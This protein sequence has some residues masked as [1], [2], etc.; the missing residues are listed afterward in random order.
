MKKKILII[1][2]NKE[3]RENIV[4]ILELS[5]FQVLSASNGKMGVEKALKVIPD[6][7][8]CDIIMPE[9][10][11]YGVLHSLQKHPQTAVIP[12]IFLTAKS[13]KADFRKGMGLGADDYL[14][15]P[16]EDIELLNAI[17]TRLKKSEIT[18]Q[19]LKL[20]Q[21][22]QEQGM[23]LEHSPGKVAMSLTSENREV[24]KYRKKH[25]LYSQ[26][27]RPMVVYFIL[28]GKVKVF[29][30][31]E[32]GK[33]LITDIHGPGDFVGFAPIL[34]ESYYS[35]EAEILED[36]ELMI[37]PKQ[38]FLT[39]INSDNQ[40]AAQF[41]KLLARNVEEKEQ[42]LLTLAY[43]S[44]RKRVARGLLDLADKFKPSQS[45]LPLIDISRENLAH[46]IGTA[47]E[48]LIRT[49]SDFKSEKLIDIKEGKILILQEKKLQS[50]LF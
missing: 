10:D 47:T 33:E 24:N 9:L 18:T 43:T 19:Q 50:L 3:I 36:A 31:H 23:I 44:L 1:E 46:T 49:L 48:S 20:N 21:P 17:D 14:C 35:D 30:V 4:E 11:G 27:Q 40:I 22:Q 42:K 29:R 28:S 37:I 45:E 34:E 41:I 39:L 8:I 2:D 32:D 25:T 16:F 15:K 7:I 5:N 26:G 6:L 38:E 13:E 12:F